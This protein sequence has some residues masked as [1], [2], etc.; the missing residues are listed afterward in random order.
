MELPAG[1]RLAV[2]IV[3]GLLCACTEPPSGDYERRPGSGCGDEPSECE[4][5]QT[6]WACVERRW[7]LVDCAERCAGRGGAAGCLEGEDLPGKARC[8]CVDDTA[9]CVPEQ[10]DCRD[11]VLRTCDPETLRWVESRCDDVCAAMSP[12]Q[13]SEGCS[14]DRCRCTLE[15]APCAPDS[16][17][18]CASFALASCV[19]GLWKVERCACSPGECNPWAPG[20]PACDC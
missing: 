17:P 15:G 7:D 10:R 1:H 18:R 19:D 4:D 8:W 6:L 2:A 11:E 20:G 14:S 3:T 5:A 12:P 13:R 16:P 9:E